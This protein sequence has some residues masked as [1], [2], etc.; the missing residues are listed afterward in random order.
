M[1]IAADVD[2]QTPRNKAVVVMIYRALNG[3]AG[4]RSSLRA[5]MLGRRGILGRRS[6]A[7]VMPGVVVNDRGASAGADVRQV[8]VCFGSQSNVPMRELVII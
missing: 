6:I 8:P 4:E 1:P 7:I 5:T 3:E 2:S